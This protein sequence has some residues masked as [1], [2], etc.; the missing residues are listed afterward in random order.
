MAVTEQLIGYEIKSDQD[1][2]QRLEQQVKAY[3]FFFD[4]NY[5]VIGKSRKN[6]IKRHIP[7]EWGLICVT[8]DDIC[9]ERKAAVNKRVKR[10]RQLSIL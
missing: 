4:K 10:Y 6:S 9:I 2:Y 1:N 8:E 7:D 3:D 5:I